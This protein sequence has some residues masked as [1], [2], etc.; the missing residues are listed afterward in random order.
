MRTY[1]IEMD[2]VDRAAGHPMAELDLADDQ[3]ADVFRPPPRRIWPD[4]FDVSTHR[5][6]GV[7]WFEVDSSGVGISASFVGSGRSGSAAG[8]WLRSGAFVGSRSF[9][10]DS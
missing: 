6:L 3:P 8:F 9:D 1:R 5:S 7:W 10:V 4:E 2:D